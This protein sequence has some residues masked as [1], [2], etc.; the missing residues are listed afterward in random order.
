[1]CPLS[2]GQARSQYVS[3]VYN[4]RLTQHGITASTGSVGDSYD[5][6]L[7]ENVNGPSQERASPYPQVG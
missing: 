6:A 4:Q 1:M 7:A 5:N 2:G 3:V